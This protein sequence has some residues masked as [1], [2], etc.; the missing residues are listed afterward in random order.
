M[1]LEQAN[2]EL[3][4]PLPKDIIAP[5]GSGPAVYAQK[6]AAKIAKPLGQKYPDVSF[7]LGVVHRDPNG[8][9]SS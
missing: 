5:S 6:A 1:R 2:Q 4:W 7:R 9:S 8:E 3:K